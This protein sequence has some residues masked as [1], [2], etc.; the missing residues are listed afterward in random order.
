MNRQE[1]I[2][3][4][5]NDAEVKDLTSNQVI[6][7]SVAV[8]KSYTKKDTGEKVTQTTWFECAKWGN[9]TQIAQYLKKGQQVYISGQPNNRAWQNENGEIK[10]VNGIL[11]NEIQ[12]LGS[13]KENGT[14]NTLN[15]TPKESTVHNAIPM[16]NQEEHDD[17]PF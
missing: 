9:N 14:N 15:Q 10:V 11:V 13:A 5:G 3:H 2:G 12:L 4:I 1:I 7:F 8:S 17:L 16:Q 6:N